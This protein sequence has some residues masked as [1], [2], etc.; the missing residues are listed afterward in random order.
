MIRKT[1]TENLYHDGIVSSGPGFRRGL[2]HLAGS[3]LQPVGK[4]QH[5]LAAARQ[6]VLTDHL[7]YI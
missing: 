1:L 7:F 4:V 3:A 6:A 2:S 5:S